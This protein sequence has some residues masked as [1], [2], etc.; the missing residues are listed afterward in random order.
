MA[1]TE[2][3]GGKKRSKKKVRRKGKGEKTKKK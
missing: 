3:R 1:E 2:R